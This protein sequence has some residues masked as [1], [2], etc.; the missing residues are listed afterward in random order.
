MPVSFTHRHNDVQRSTLLLLSTVVVETIG[1]ISN[2]QW[3]LMST[4]QNEIFLRLHMF[5]ASAL[6]GISFHVDRF[7][8]VEEFP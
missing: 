4:E 8:Y 1:V 7:V 2:R 5:V 6:R 3:I